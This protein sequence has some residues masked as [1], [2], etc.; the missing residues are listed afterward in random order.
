MKDYQLSQRSYYAVLHHYF[1][2]QETY[3]NMCCHL[4]ERWHFIMLND[5]SRNQAY[6][7]ALCNEIR[8]FNQKIAVCDVGC[9]TGLLSL[10]ASQESNCSHVFAIEKS[11]IMCNVANEVFRANLV[12]DCI[13][14]VKVIN[15]MSTEM[16]IPVHMPLKADILVTE[17]FDAGLFGEGIL[18]TLCHAWSNLLKNEQEKGM[19]IPRKAT[20]YLQAIE[21]DYICNENRFAGQFCDLN[22][23]DII[24][25]S[26]IG[27]C[28]SDPYTT[29]D[30]K[31][32]PG[33]YKSLSPCIQF[34][35]VDFN[36]PQDLHQL[37]Q[38][39]TKQ[40]CVNIVEDGRLDALAMWF[41]LDLSDNVQISTH[42]NCNGCWEQ[43]IFSVHTPKAI[44]KLESR[45][46]S[47][48]NLNVYKGDNINVVQCVKGGKLC[49]TVS[50]VIQLTSKE[51][52][53]PS[54]SDVPKL[55]SNPLDWCS[56]QVYCLS[57]WEVI[58][59]NNNN[60]HNLI[61]NC[62]RKIISKPRTI[63]LDFVHLNHGFSPMV[64][65]ASKLGY[66]HCTAISHNPIHLSLL[67]TLITECCLQD[68]SF[69]LVEDLDGFI[70]MLDIPGQDDSELSSQHRPGEEPDGGQA[71]QASGT[72][73]ECP[74]GEKSSK[75][76]PEAEKTVVF[77]CDVV[78]FQ[79]RMV[80]NLS[81]QLKVA[82]YCMSNYVKKTVLPYCV[83]VFGVLVESED[84]LRLSRIQNDDNTLGY[85]I[86]SF[87]NKFSSSNYQG[88]TL[89]T[90]THTK[91]SKPF[92]M[93]TLNL[94]RM[95]DGL[96]ETKA[97]PEDNQAGC[98]VTSKTELD[99]PLAKQGTHCKS[100]GLSSEHEHV[101]D[102]NFTPLSELPD[103]SGHD[104]N[105]NFVSDKL[106][107]QDK[108]HAKR[109]SSEFAVEGNS[110]ENENV[111]ADG[112]KR[113]KVNLTDSPSKTSSSV[114]DDETEMEQHKQIKV[115]VVNPGCVTALV[116][117]FELH[118]SPTVRVNTLDSHL[119]W[120]Q[121]AVMA[122]RKWSVDTGDI[123]D[124]SCRLANSAINFNINK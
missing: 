100:V 57:D 114:T 75:V 21:S 11:S 8:K 52:Q 60:L 45:E 51:S 30:L 103:T 71:G 68:H 112:I 79:G 77:L 33:G 90:L 67:K 110:L 94:T 48:L 63:T 104:A 98:S 28:D 96:N 116:Y 86:A 2:A 5:K 53:P 22:L 78:D 81:D 73:Q 93:F 99:G 49:M 13:H 65:A 1:S 89:S 43:A 91:L 87:F 108:T 19:V 83:E 10:I 25:C 69:T 106:V 39:I 70:E 101:L 92:K 24:I 84:L 17:T 42:T 44:E 82:K 119:H 58:N 36:N 37:N 31:H 32:L 115:S 72:G 111:L 56:Q 123:L 66:D 80:E 27:M 23:S 18:P 3:E 55:F 38:G 118:I 34:M 124:L 47:R 29:H 88:I 76:S 97:I 16:R 4:V 20:L 50:D 40:L 105:S 12:E 15:K 41:S 122:N 14:K 35:D 107:T 113:R 85:N 54:L 102:Q 9:G 120:Q 26:T 61:Y 46:G 95:M 117:W 121:A 64:L 7:K 62:L 74:T 109:I 6:Q 59:L